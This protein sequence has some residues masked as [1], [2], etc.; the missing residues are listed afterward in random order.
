[1]KNKSLSLILLFGLFACQE[2]PDAAD[3]NSD[4]EKS[5]GYI[6]KDPEYEKQLKSLS[7]FIG[8]VFKD[9]GARDELFSFSKLEGNQGEV[10]YSLAKLF[11]ENIDPLSRRKSAIV[12]AFY[13]GA[14]SKTFS[15]GGQKVEDMVD[16]I[17]E[18][19]IGVIAPYMAE[20]FES[21]DISELT[22]SWWSQDYED[23]NLAL[24]STWKGETEAALVD[25]GSEIPLFEEDENNQ[26]TILV[27]D[28]YAKKNPTLVL[29]AFDYLDEDESVQSKTKRD[30]NAATQAYVNSANCSQ[31]VPTSLVKLMMPEF[32]LTNS[33]R[34]WPHPDRLK[35]LIVLGTNPGGSGYSN[36]IFDQEVKRK[37]TGK[38]LT[39]PVSFLIN[40][41]ADHQ[42]DMAMVLFNKKPRNSDGVQVTTV[43][44]IN[45]SGQTETQVTT[46]GN[47]SDYQLHFKQTFNKCGT[48]N[49]P[50]SNRG[51]GQRSSAGVN[52]GVERFGKFMFYLKPQI[53]L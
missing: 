38:W 8:E 1:M 21:G 40:S 4:M 26:N 15:S 43:I 31:L 3:V 30:E 34:A 27:S 39:A 49:D 16:F 53:Q 50:F 42:V 18:N 10:E 5:I 19:N 28:E 35:L 46:V 24:D 2:I 32:Q 52:Y 45:S 14:K 44:K 41:W 20:N 22:V 9:K 12:D 6:A 7:L 48:I 37:D 13:R 17:K 25:L 29:G 23:W 11:E 51:F 36:T 33:I 47:F